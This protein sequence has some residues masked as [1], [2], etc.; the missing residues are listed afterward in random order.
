MPFFQRWLTSP[1]SL[2]GRA[3]HARERCVYLESLPVLCK[4]AGLAGAPSFECYLLPYY[5]QHF[6]LKEAT[7]IFFFFLKCSLISSVLQA[8]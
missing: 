2:V 4:A 7:R 1:S 6:S 3:S 5:I 8:V